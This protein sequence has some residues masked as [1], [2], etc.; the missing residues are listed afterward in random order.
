[1]SNVQS[2]GQRPKVVA[3]GLGKFNTG[4]RQPSEAK[5]GS[6]GKAK[7]LGYSLFS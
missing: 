6:L 2:L 1:M 4:R 5:A 3:V 7:F